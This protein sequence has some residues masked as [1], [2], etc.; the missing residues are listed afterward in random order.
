MVICKQRQL[1]IQEDQHKCDTLSLEQLGKQHIGTKAD[2][3][4]IN[5]IVNHKVLQ[6]FCERSFIYIIN[7]IFIE[8]DI[9]FH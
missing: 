1:N 6:K 5:V 4:R 7:G 2:H 9:D 8:I 3:D